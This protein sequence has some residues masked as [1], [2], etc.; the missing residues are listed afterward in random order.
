MGYRAAP[1]VVRL[2]ERW[3]R[4]ASAMSYILRCTLSLRAAR[5]RLQ[6]DAVEC[7]SVGG[8]RVA[9]VVFEESKGLKKALTVT[10]KGLKSPL[11][12][13][14]EGGARSKVGLKGTS[15][16]SPRPSVIGQHRRVPCWYDWVVSPRVVHGGSA[17][18]GRE[19]GVERGGRRR[20]TQR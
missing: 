6:V 17:L 5:R 16:F 1:D 4:T 13:T 7:S 19:T 10:A 12:C 20:R 15:L 11:V 8:A 14:T 3:K 18:R 2:R 9:H